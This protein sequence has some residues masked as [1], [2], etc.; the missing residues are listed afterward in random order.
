MAI[1]LYKLVKPQG[2]EISYHDI[3]TFLETEKIDR[4]TGGRLAAWAEQFKFWEESRALYPYMEVGAPFRKHS[5]LMRQAIDP[6]PGQVWLDAGCGP[7]KMSE[8]VWEKSN[9]GVKKIIGLDIILW[10]AM[11]TAKKIPV[12]EL[13]YGN[14]G[15]RLD[16]PDNTFDG[17]VSNLVVSY[18]TEFEGAKGKDGIQKVFEEFARVLKPGG[19]L[20]W[21]TIIKNLHCEITFACAIPGVIASLKEN[22]EIFGTAIYL[23]RYGKKLEE[24]GKK[25]IYTLL[26]TSEWNDMLIKAGF[27]NLEWKPVFIEQ[28]LIGS[29]YRSY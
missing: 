2:G 20:V 13:K 23:Y 19:Q 18:I 10:P 1:G 26:S 8:Y 21:S 25:G 5:G 3:I 27:V 6:K 7:A 16:F 17:I 29:C 15:E 14:L 9:H 4:E 24:N 11:K 28:S 22:P 12:M